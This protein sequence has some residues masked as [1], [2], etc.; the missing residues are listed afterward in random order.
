[1]ATYITPC[2]TC[3]GESVCKRAL[4]NIKALDSKVMRANDLVGDRLA[5]KVL[6]DAY[7]SRYTDEPDIHGSCSSHKSVTLKSRVWHTNRIPCEQCRF[8]DVCSVDF[9]KQEAFCLAA[10]REMQGVI[11][12]SCAC[13][14]LYGDK[15]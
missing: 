2:S 10:T 1:M 4:H 9:D 13:Y 15:E 14:E 3:L 8:K 5:V 11:K 12:L 7:S 6:C